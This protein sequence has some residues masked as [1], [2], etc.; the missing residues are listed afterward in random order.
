MLLRKVAV[1]VGGGSGKRLWEGAFIFILLLVLTLVGFLGIPG[2]CSQEKGIREMKRRGV[3][4]P[5]KE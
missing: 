1:V 2:K 5:T 4:G 3:A